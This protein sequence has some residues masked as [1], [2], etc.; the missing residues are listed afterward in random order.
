MTLL[1]WE[2]FACWNPLASPSLPNI[3]EDALCVSHANI[4]PWRGT[5]WSFSLTAECCHQVSPQSRKRHFT[6]TYST[7][8]INNILSLV[9]AIWEQE[10]KQCPHRRE[11][12]TVLHTT[13]RNYTVKQ[14]SKAVSRKA[15]NIENAFI[16]EVLFLAR[17]KL[18]SILEVL[19]VYHPAQQGDR[20]STVLTTFMYKTIQI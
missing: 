15:T 2:T 4:R 9:G 20:R 16:D 8:K 1:Y 6:R 11:V 12:D 13:L 19:P 7:L 18:C 10:T 5:S 17:L 14:L 3:R